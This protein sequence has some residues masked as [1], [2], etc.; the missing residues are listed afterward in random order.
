MGGDLPDGLRGDRHGEFAMSDDPRHSD[1]DRLHVDIAAH[2]LE[3]DAGE[4]GLDILHHQLQRLVS[5]QNFIVF[6]YDRG[7]NPTLIRTNRDPK[8]LAAQMRDY[9]RGLH[10]LDPFCRVDAEGGSG[11]YRLGNIAPESFAESEFYR[12][13]YR[14]TGVADE[15]RFIARLAPTIS[16]HIFVEREDPEPDFSPGELDRLEALTPIVLAFVRSRLSGD[17]TDQPVASAPKRV[18][19]LAERIGLM[20]PDALTERE[21]EIV[22]LMLKGHSAKSAARVLGIEGGTV[23]NHKRNIY[24]KLEVHSQAQLFDLFLRTL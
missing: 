15:L 22:E 1:P 11:L 2:L 5:Y 17:G 24:A 12:R 14:Y 4:A 19:N 20:R 23:A 10:M 18:F 13:H 3:A 6:L 21:V 9:V 8:I 16:A 7:R